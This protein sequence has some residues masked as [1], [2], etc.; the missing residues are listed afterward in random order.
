MKKDRGKRE[1]WL[2]QTIQEPLRRRRGLRPVHIS[3]PST[4]TGWEKLRD[5]TEE[6]NEPS[7]AP[8]PPKRVT[9]C[10]RPLY[11]TPGKFC[12]SYPACAS[13][14]TEPYCRDC[15]SVGLTK[16]ELAERDN[17]VESMTQGT[18]TVAR[19][20][21][22]NVDFFVLLE[23]FRHMHMRKRG[24]TWADYNELF[25]VLEA[26]GFV[27]KEAR[28]LARGYFK[29]TETKLDKLVPTEVFVEEYVKLQWHVV[30]LTM[31]AKVETFGD[32]LYQDTLLDISKLQGM[33]TKQLGKRKAEM[34]C[35]QLRMDFGKKKILPYT[36]KVA[37]EELVV[38]YLQKEED[39]RVKRLEALAKVPKS[40]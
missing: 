11:F 1:Q 30:M 20:L 19:K 34:E 6:I 21:V 15:L 38:W 40:S 35:R 10:E 27:R 39:V 23:C 17:I 8:N 9:Y 4:Q 25:T 26:A 28:S 16:Y 33:L 32:K 37:W 7:V 2:T 3:K 13:D 24:G 18:P 5:N 12:L 22:S 29:L 31:R 36:N 14:E